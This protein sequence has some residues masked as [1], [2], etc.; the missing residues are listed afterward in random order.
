MSTRLH[1]G[2]TR[3]ASL[4]RLASAL[5]AWIVAA[6]CLPLQA[7]QAAADTAHST[8]SRKGRASPHLLSARFLKFCKAHHQ[9]KVTDIASLGVQVYDDPQGH[10]LV[11]THPAF[12]AY[13][14]VERLEGPNVDGWV[15]ENLKELR[16]ARVVRV[17]FF[18]E[19]DYSG[20]IWYA[21]SR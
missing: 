15:A 10:A 4:P 6:A 2:H 19:G 8:E 9:G 20:G 7:G 12:A 1:S 21:V 5:A 17:G 3:S 18:G 14:I 13:A 11:C 16:A